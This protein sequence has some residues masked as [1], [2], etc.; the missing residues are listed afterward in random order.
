MML[1]N[2]AF[3][4]MDVNTVKVYV[5]MDGCI[6]YLCMCVY[7]CMYVCPCVCVC[8]CVYVCMYV[9]RYVCRYVFPEAEGG[10]IAVTK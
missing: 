1:F 2:L 3:I 7:V 8:V 6:K 4:T 9:R 10:G 5:C